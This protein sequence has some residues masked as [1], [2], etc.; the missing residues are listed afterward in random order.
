MSSLSVSASR[1]RPVEQP[2]VSFDAVTSFFD[3]KGDELSPDTKL[4]AFK[5]STG[6]LP[7]KANEAVT[8]LKNQVKGHEDSYG[9]PRVLS[10]TIQGQKTIW[11]QGWA[12][13]KA[14][15][16]SNA[17]N[18]EGQQSL[19][20]FTTAG[21]LIGSAFMPETGDTY[22]WVKNPLSLLNAPTAPA[23]R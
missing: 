19:Y 10:A 17:T 9:N 15:G 21:A 11:V 12:G 4:K 7:S 13:N 20:V 16:D 14:L 23:T 22:K 2:S 1:T 6:K 8:F 3:K 5:P 18:D